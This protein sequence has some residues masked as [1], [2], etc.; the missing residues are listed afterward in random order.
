M[1]STRKRSKCQL[2]DDLLAIGLKNGEFLRE[3]HLPMEKE[4]M[5][6]TTD[7]CTLKPRFDVISKLVQSFF[8]LPNSKADFERAF[9]NVEKNHTEFRFEL[10]NETLNALLSCKFNQSA[11]LQQSIIMLLI[12]LEN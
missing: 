3:Q 12:K 4:Y 9:S 2:D 10:S 11:N 7:I 1:A 6:T 5:K 8:V